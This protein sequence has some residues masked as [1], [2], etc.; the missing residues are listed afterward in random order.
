MIIQQVLIRVK[1]CRGEYGKC[2]ADQLFVGVR[3]LTFL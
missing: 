1:K 2:G 3:R